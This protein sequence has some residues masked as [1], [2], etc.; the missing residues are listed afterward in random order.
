MSIQLESRGIRLDLIPARRD[1]GTAGN[2]L[3]NKRSGAAVQTDVAQHV[4]LIANSGRQQEICAL[5]I[6]RQRNE[7]DFPSLYLELSVLNALEGERFGQVADNVLI[8]LRYLAGRFESVTVRDPANAK[9]V[10]SGDLSAGEKKA[11]AKAARN[12]I[13]DENWKKIL[14]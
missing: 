9:N 13:Y 12:A 1:G 4:H 11:I 3:F 7:L 5:K 6:W 8:A 2:L 10:V 14:W